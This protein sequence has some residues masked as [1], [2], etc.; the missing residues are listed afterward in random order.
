MRAPLLAVLAVA[1]LFAAPALAQ[2]AKPRPPAA[3][4]GGVR[5][6]APTSVTLT[7]TVNPRGLAT[8]Y[9]FQYGA[10]TTLN[11]RTPLK[12]LPAGSANKRVA[13]PVTVV[14]N[15]RY[16]YRLVAINSAGATQGKTAR[17]TSPR[18]AAA[19]TFAARS[20]RVSYEGAAVFT[21]NA[22][23]LGAGNVA[24][25]LEQQPFPYTGAFAPVATQRSGSDGSYSFTVSPL[26]LSSRFR[27]VARTTPGVT[28]AVLTVRTKVRVA[29]KATRLSGRRVRFSGDIVPAIGAG[30]VSLQ[31]RTGSG[32]WITIRRAS[33]RHPSAD[34][35]SYRITVGARRVATRYRVRVTPAESSGYVRGTSRQQR[36][37]GRR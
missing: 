23:T 27:L 12:Q 10:G 19:L 32:Q 20:T 8:Q 1:T 11:R 35:A 15:R 37:A 26:L 6:L 29:I 3:T 30:R 22:T 36:L 16:S 24:L 13:A 14:A 21:G 31:R 18:G 33:V 25:V 4:T 9:R 7:G 2:T 17:F 28:S 5:D 34:R